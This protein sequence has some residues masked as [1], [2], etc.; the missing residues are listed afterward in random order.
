MSDTED[1]CDVRIQYGD[2][3]AGP[4]RLRRSDVPWLQAALKTGCTVHVSDP[5]PGEKFNWVATIE[6]DP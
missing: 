2:L 5:A 3:N 6:V 1:L 4:Y